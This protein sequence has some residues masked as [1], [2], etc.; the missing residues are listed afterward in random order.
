MELT[1]QRTRQTRRSAEKN[2]FVRSDLQEGV[3]EEMT[4]KEISMTRNPAK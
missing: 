2:W 3:S 1:A 4:F